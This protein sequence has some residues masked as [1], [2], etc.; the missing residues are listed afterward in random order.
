M[1][2]FSG[3]LKV[4]ALVLMV[5]GALGIGFGFFD[6]ASKTMEDAKEVIA[7][8][9]AVAA[10]KAAEAELKPQYGR[11]SQAKAVE[12]HAESHDT[13]GHD[14]HADAHAEDKH[15]AHVLHQLHNRPWAAVLVAMFYLFMIALSIFAFYTIQ[16]AASAGWS[17]VLLRLMEALSASLVPI[18]ILIFIF[19][20]ASAFGMNHI[21]PW[22]HAEGDAIIEGKKFWLN[23]PGWLLRSFVV[24]AGFIFF[25]YIIIKKNRE[26]DDANDLSAH[27]KG[28]K[29]AVFFL[30]FFMVAETVLSW[31][32]IMSLDPHWFSSLFGWYVFS[33]AIVSAITVIALAV[34]YL[35]IKGHL[36]FVNDSHIP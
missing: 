32:W 24:I 6:G 15:V 31:D 23:I 26:Q 29:Y 16:I 34:I 5:I 10:E 8:H 14:D 19:L 25:R 3:R 13:H 7:H 2:E 17:V 9:E 22:M 27:K 11:K 35:K 1:Y 33:T 21:Y 30:A 28:F 20:L 12:K 4:T 18:G 36:E